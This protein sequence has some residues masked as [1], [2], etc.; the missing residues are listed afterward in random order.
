[1]GVGRCGGLAQRGAV[2]TRCRGVWACG[3]VRGCGAGGCT[4]LGGTHQGDVAA[5]V[6]RPPPF[7]TAAVV[8]RSTHA[9]PDRRSCGLLGRHLLGPPGV[10]PVCSYPSRVIALTAPPSG[11]HYQT[12]QPAGWLTSIVVC[13]RRTR[14]TWQTGAE[15]ALLRPSIALTLTSRLSWKCVTGPRPP[16]GPAQLRRPADA[17]PLPLP[18]T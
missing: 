15:Q 11:S 18:L 4:L 12:R 8:L 3:C 2:I 1:M 14:P 10:H 7:S 5:G 17:A 13:Q 9:A 6:L 16:L